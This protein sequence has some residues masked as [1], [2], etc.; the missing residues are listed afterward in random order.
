MLT[1][2]ERGLVRRLQQGEPDAVDRL[3]DLYADRLYRHIYHRVGQDSAAAEDV[4]QETL[5]AALRGIKRFRGNARL[6]TWLYSIAGHKAAD[7]HRRQARQRRWRQPSS[8][9]L[10]ELS[11]INEA[12]LP[13]EVVQR[14]D[15]RAAVRAALKQLPDHYR[16]VLVL[17]YIDECTVADI[18]ETVGKSFKSVESTL[19]RAR[20]ALRKLLAPTV[21]R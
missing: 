3:C 4:L 14:E 16:Q 15:V 11:G 6:A 21:K 13:E 9:S 8:A 10:E 2:E 20:R 1:E 7:W 19:V 12:P 18:S 17:K 5:L